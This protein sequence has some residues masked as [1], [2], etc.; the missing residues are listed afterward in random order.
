MWNGY[1]PFA[2]RDGDQMIYKG[3]FVTSDSIEPFVGPTIQ[4][5]RH[6]F[7]SGAVAPPLFSV[8]S[9]YLGNYS[10]ESWERQ[11]G[12]RVCAR[13]SDG[14]AHGLALTH[15]SLRRQ[16]G[17][18]RRSWPSVPHASQ[19]HPPPHAPPPRR[20]RR[21]RP[22]AL[23]RRWGCRGLFARR[24]WRRCGHLPPRVPRQ[25]PRPP[26]QPGPFPSLGR[27]RSTGATRA[28]LRP[29]RQAP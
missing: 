27:Q 18:A 17:A 5:D 11:H 4:I 15:R 16:R 8:R 22:P 10:D 6:K 12:M 25:C 29:Q 28:R 19:A 7:D 23:P 2:V 9:G 13:E 3:R 14:D 21:P 1:I 20:S 26:V 24:L